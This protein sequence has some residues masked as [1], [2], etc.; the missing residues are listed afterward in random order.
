MLDTDLGFDISDYKDNASTAPGR[1]RSYYDA[2]LTK[3]NRALLPFSCT[4]KVYREVAEA[5]AF[6]T[7]SLKAGAGVKLT[8]D[9]D[10]KLCQQKPVKGKLT[11]ATT[12]LELEPSKTGKLP[13]VLV[14][15]DSMETEA[16]LAGHCGIIDGFSM[17][18]ERLRAGKDVTLDLHLLR[19]ADSQN[20]SGMRASGPESFAE[21]YNALSDYLTKPS[22]ATLL[23][24]FGKLNSVVRKGFFK[25]GIITSAMDYANPL[26]LDYLAADLISIDGSHK[27]GAIVDE[28]INTEAMAEVKAAT[29]AAVNE[30]SLFLQKRMFDNEGIAIFANVCQGIY[31]RD[32]ATCLIWRIN[33]GKCLTR[34]ALIEA[35]K[36]STLRLC[37]THATWRPEKHSWSALSDDR[38]IAVD[39]MGVANLLALT[40][41]K[42]N[43]F[44][45]ELKAMLAGE[46]GEFLS[47][48]EA[49]NQAVFLP[50]W[51][52]AAYQASTAVAD[53]FM[54]ERNL[55][56]LER[57]H[58]I[59][60]AQSHSYTTTDTQ[61]NTTCRG[62]WAPL[63]RTVNRISDVEAN[64][65][66]YHGK[67]ETALEVGAEAH[68]EYA[69]LWQELMN[70][71]GRPHA[72]SYDTY[73]PASEAMFDKWM[74][75]PLHTIY[76]NFSSQFDQSYSRKT[77][78]D[79]DLDFDDVEASAEVDN[80]VGRCSVCAE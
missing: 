12:G 77:A 3:V 46:R 38:Q 41:W 60:P 7:R 24:L 40:G 44:F 29:I 79:L 22:M 6:C 68:Y 58:T 32:L 27:K 14:L 13:L 5:M 18:T 64:V 2:Q 26:Y 9:S 75:G 10:F 42:Y 36:E 43:D 67:V 34:T 4:L 51:F 71:Y 59:E 15:Q 39:F 1:I 78:R 56:L 52:A 17:V 31:M 61:G 65:T 49:S 37:Q 73:E 54:R 35:T 63:G 55:P 30:Q 25:R 57:I 48:G 69:C 20:S 33:A 21:L 80:Q 19:P 72:I 76:Y 47:N 70:R 23:Q 62:F 16:D 45:A 53:E 50:E 28:G 8:F 74:A 66:V 11:I